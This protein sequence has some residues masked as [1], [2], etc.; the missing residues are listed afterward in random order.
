M[1]ASITRLN[2]PTMPDAAAAGYS[3]ISIAEAGRIACIS[4]QVAWSSDGSPVPAT[5]GGQAEL[6]V[7]NAKAAL[8]AIGATANDLMIVRVYLV[9]LDEARLGELWPHLHELFDGEQPSLTGIG[10]AA[11]AGPD[12]QVE[13]EMTVRVP[14]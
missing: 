10:V 13:I 9:G 2:P 7:R 1:T 3:Q 5:L 4:G 11:L 12:L 8:A 14:G 6:V